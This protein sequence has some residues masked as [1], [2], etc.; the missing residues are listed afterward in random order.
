[1]KAYYDERHSGNMT[2]YG[3]SCIDDWVVFDSWNIKVDLIHAGWKVVTSQNYS[4]S[5]IYM[6]SVRGDASL[7]LG[8]TENTQINI[9]EKI[10]ETVLEAA[11]NKK[12]VIV[13]DNQVE[14][15][16]FLINNINAYDVI[17]ETMHKLRLPPMSLII[18]TGNAALEHEYNSWMRD[19]LQ[20]K[21]FEHVPCISWAARAG[22]GP[23]LERPLVLDA[24]E[25]KDSK[26]FISMNRNPRPHRLDHIFTLLDGDIVE[27]GLVSGCIGSTHLDTTYIEAHYAYYQAQLTANCPLIIDEDWTTKDP[28]TQD[29]TTFPA[30]QFGNSLLSFVTESEFDSPGLFV[31]EKTFKPLRAGHPFI[32]L[33][34]PFMLQLLRDNGYRTDFHSIDNSYDQMNDH[35]ERFAAAHNELF[36]WVNKS[37]SEKISAIEQSMDTILHNFNHFK[38]QQYVTQSFKNLLITTQNI[39]SDEGIF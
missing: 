11:R 23:E 31:T 30:E 22:V 5:G 35:K 24:I 32:L 29:W 34:Q 14:G 6:V 27:K 26:D 21:M 10:P 19:T 7:W 17:Y 15:R 9:L 37:R 3:A 8:K 36:K 28:N 13:I 16:S 25:N 1:M 12:L 38:E 4:R 2:L 39:L 18:M 20:D 33:A